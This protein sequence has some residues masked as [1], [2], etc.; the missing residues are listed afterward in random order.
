MIRFDCDYVEGAHPA[1]LEAMIRTNMEQTVGYGEDAYCESAR[2][3]IR[4]ACRAPEAGVHFLVG[5]T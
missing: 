1:I 3:R 5:G 4:A 2:A